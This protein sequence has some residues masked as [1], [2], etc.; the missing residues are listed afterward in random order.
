MPEQRFV[1][2][3]R[4]FAPSVDL[5]PEKTAL[6]IIDMQYHDASADHGVMLAVEKMHPGRTA[7]YVDRVENTV[8]PTLQELLKYCRANGVRVIYLT[9]GSDY[10]D[11]RDFPEPFRRGFRDLENASG[12][13][14]IMWS[15]NPAF[16]IREEIAPRD[17]EQVIKKTTFGA[18]SSTNLAEVLRELGVESLVIT[19]VSTNCCV[20]STARD[21]A[22]RGFGCVVV[23]EGTADYTPEA[24]DAS[25]RAFHGSFGRVM[26][27]AS[28]VI[29]ALEAASPASAR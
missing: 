23:D 3:G 9:L 2:Y 17:E 7:Y 28:D 5:T 27:S 29:A 13:S 18:F 20:E 12:V 26:K 25:L 8:I 10:R 4:A 24:Q 11:L 19:G 15:Q 16:A 14:D 22:D 1:D 21:A 6:M